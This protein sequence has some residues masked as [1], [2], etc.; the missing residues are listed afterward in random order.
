MGEEGKDKTHQIEASLHFPLRMTTVVDLFLV[1]AQHSA[2]RFHSFSTS[3]I[4]AIRNSNNHPKSQIYRITILLL[5]EV[6]VLEEVIWYFRLLHSS[7]CLKKIQAT[8]SQC[9]KHAYQFIFVIYVHRV[10]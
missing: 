4:Q 7:A 1:Y 5:E 6:I 8:R 3:T 2:A 10:E 9:I